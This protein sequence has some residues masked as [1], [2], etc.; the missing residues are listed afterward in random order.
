MA[1][2]IESKIVGME[3]RENGAAEEAAL[4]GSAAN[5]VV[6]M[7]EKLER[8]PT[9]TGSTYKI[10]TPTSE[11]SMYVTIN[12]IVLNPGTEHEL[13]RPFE[14]FINSKNMDHFQWIVALT[15]II[16]AVFRKGGDVTF[17]VE[18]LHSVF[19]PRGGYFKKGGK[20]MPSLVGE[21][22]DVLEQHLIS[23]GILKKEGLDEHRSKFVAEK[24]AEADLRTGV[25]SS[26]E[27]NAF[28]ASATLCSKCMTKAV[29]YMDGC[30][31]CL[32][33]GESKCG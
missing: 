17:L 6:H 25:D 31:T 1:K 9:L 24:R 29:I 2:K 21:I 28:P 12:D 11:H 14:I 18:E 15:R 23:I 26:S 16:S 3:V 7:H 8:P 5:N 10:R 27:N 33:C 22:G 4:V 13:R 30:L 19:D 32:N 20:F